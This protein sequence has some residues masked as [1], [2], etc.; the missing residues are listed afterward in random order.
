[1]EQSLCF[2]P[3]YRGNKNAYLRDG[4]AVHGD[5]DGMWSFGYDYSTD[6]T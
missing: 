3:P 6:A 1:M 5:T 4:F 2:Y